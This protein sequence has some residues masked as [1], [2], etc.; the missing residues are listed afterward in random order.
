MQV[1]NNLTSI[2]QAISK[3]TCLLLISE[4]PL[5]QDPKLTL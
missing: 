3:H 4:P 2:K 1:S 5:Q